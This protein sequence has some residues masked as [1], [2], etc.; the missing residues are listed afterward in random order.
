MMN[1]EI[2]EKWLNALESGEYSQTNGGLKDTNGY[3]CLGVL[4]DLYIKEHNV[5]WD[6]LVYDSNLDDLVVIPVSKLETEPSHRE[7]EFAG[8]GEILPK[9]VSE[10]AGLNGNGNPTLQAFHP[11]Y[12]GDTLLIDLNDKGKTFSEIAQLIRQHGVA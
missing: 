2:Q 9:V 11:T 7:Y 4:C 10:W 3:C 8:E 1:P 5:E 12:K 6:C